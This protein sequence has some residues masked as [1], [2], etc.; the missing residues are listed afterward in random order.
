LATKIVVTDYL[1]PDFNWE[2][3][4]LRSQ[5]FD[6]AWSEC[7][8]KF[9]S[10]AELVPAIADAEVIVVNMARMNA[11]VIQK[12]TRCKLIIRHGIGYDNVD[13]KAATA[14]GIRVA[15]IP[16]YC[17]E[18]V[19]E[20]TVMLIL[21][22]ARHMAEQQ[23]SMAASVAKGQWDFSS[24]RA[25]YQM[26]GKTLGVIGCGRIG[27]RVLRKMAG[28]EMNAIICDPY[29]SAERQKALGVE[30]IAFERVLRDADIITL[31]TPM[32]DETR[33]LINRHTLSLMKKTTVLVNTARGP[34]IVD[35]DL[36]DALNRGVIAG[37]ALDVYHREPPPPSSPLLG[38]ANCLLTPHLS[39]YSEESGW[40]IREKILENIV[41]HLQ[42]RPPRFTVN[43]EVEK[44][45]AR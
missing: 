11:E 41:L 30:T 39:W 37:A 27:S 38:L 25:V 3:E 40:S 42:G 14:R 12:L 16:D 29:L 15:N 33:G 5:G 2:K 7:Q 4:Q 45:L 20:Q 21:S 28:L 44:A 17:V 19:A 31:H 36:A 1:E 23:V 10:E 13:L 26:K 18:E 35:E 34:L 24:V 8:L 22:A 43:P 32:N 6:F 9:A